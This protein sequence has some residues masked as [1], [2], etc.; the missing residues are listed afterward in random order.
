MTQG[1]PCQEPYLLHFRMDIET[2]VA[3]LGNL[4]GKKL[5]AIDRVTKDDGLIDLELHEGREERREV[6]TNQLGERNE[7]RARTSCPLRTGSQKGGREGGG[8]P[9]RRGC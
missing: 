4:L 6:G 5:D 2:R 3:E 8:V 9:W 1:R 7:V